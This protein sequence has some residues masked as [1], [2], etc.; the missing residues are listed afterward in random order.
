LGVRATHAAL[1]GALRCGGSSGQPKVIL[2]GDSAQIKPV[3]PGAGLE[4]VR[5]SA[6]DVALTKAVLS[7]SRP[8]VA[9]SSNYLVRQWYPRM[10]GSKPRVASSTLLTANSP[11]APPSIPG[12]LPERTDLAQVTFSLPER[13]RL[14]A[15]LT[16]RS[17]S[18]CARD[19]QLQGESILV[20]AETSSG[21]PFNLALAVE[22]L[23]WFG[24]RCAINGSTAQIERNRTSK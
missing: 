22:D 4:L 9:W 11:S 14:S 2:C 1:S 5:H 12:S 6:D 23:I 18:A 8:C 7:A 17:E 21:D 3:A 24:R 10:K 16:A 13:T 20:A 19:G 15:P